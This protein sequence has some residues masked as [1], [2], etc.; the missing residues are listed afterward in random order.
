MLA[1]YLAAITIVALML[2]LL[3]PFAV[4]IPFGGDVGSVRL[5]GMLVKLGA[6][7]SIVVALIAIGVAADARILATR[8]IIGSLGVVAALLAVLFFLYDGFWLQ[9]SIEVAQPWRMGDWSLAS[10]VAT[11]WISPAIALALGAFTTLSFTRRASGRVCVLWS[12]A[13]VVLVSAGT[14]S[15]F[16][17]HVLAGERWIW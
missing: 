9:G 7:A 5:G 8:V 14:W 16:G 13:A 4:A 17:E 6:Q 2:A 10:V 1:K 11:F 15:S 12:V 3:Q